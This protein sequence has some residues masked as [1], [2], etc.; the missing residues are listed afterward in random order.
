MW[1]IRRI[2]MCHKYYN[3]KLPRRP[4]AFFLYDKEE[5]VNN[6]ELWC[7]FKNFLSITTGSWHF[8]DYLFL[9]H[10]YWLKCAKGKR[11][12]VFGD[13]NT[14]AC[15][16]FTIQLNVSSHTVLNESF[17]F[18]LYRCYWQAGW[19]FTFWWSMF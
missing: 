5:Q 18:V 14:T 10:I 13:T 4:A 16:L 11:L 7:F 12:D 2:Y 6:F 9:S 15:G 19:S 3:R 1:Q 17:H 8:T